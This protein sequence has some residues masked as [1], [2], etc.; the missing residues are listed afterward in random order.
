MLAG[1]ALLENVVEKQKSPVLYGLRIA[2]LIYTRYFAERAKRLPYTD[3]ARRYAG[4]RF[5]GLPI[6]GFGQPFSHKTGPR[7]L[8]TISARASPCRRERQMTMREARALPRF[9]RCIAFDAHDDTRVLAIGHII[10]PK[11]A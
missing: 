9:E 1:T 7:A 6:D 11:A 8:A 2:A 4:P 10:S 5:R 3:D